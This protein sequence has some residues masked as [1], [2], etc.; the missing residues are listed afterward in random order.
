MFMNKLLLLAVLVV[1]AAVSSLALSESGYRLLKKIPISGD[2]PWDYVNADVLNRKIY[3]SHGSQLEVIDADS[4]ELV[5]K[6]P[7]PETD[8][9]GTSASMPVHGVA[10]A[11][12]LG[13]GFTSNGRASSMTIFDLKTLKILGEVKV[14]ESPDGI[15]Y[16]PA[17]RRA[18]TFSN[19]TKGATA[20]DGATGKLVGSID[21]GGKPEAAAADGK[22][23]V[24]VNI[25]DRDVVVRFDSRRLLAKVRWKLDPCHEPASMA[26][27]NERKRIFVGCRNKMMAV[28][29]ADNGKIVATL[30]IGGNT[31]AAA[32]DFVSR[33]VFFS[34]GD[35]TLTVIQQ[36]SA[37]R[38]KVVDNLKTEPNART[39]ALDTKT[40][41]IFLSL[42]DRGP[43]PHNPASPRRAAPKLFPAAFA[44][45][46]WGRNRR[47]RL[48]R[49]N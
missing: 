36:E 48:L 23:H 4:L 45:W 20:V 39:M 38:Y 34:N 9:S 30:P 41:R 10:I 18:F 5:G 35:G 1:A 47:N 26:I 33:L 17:S 21:L 3:V 14:G 8:H 31:D 25:E 40:H 43:L 16:D 22:G 2:G 37:D 12:E 27:D 15:L 7:A 42:A 19:H 28:L 13:R 44:C 49:G 6:I 29:N 24:F 32:Y 46:Y 11:W